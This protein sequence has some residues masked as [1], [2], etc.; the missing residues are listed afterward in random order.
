MKSFAETTTEIRKK[1]YAKA[2]HDETK[3]MILEMIGE[4]MYAYANELI[5]NQKPL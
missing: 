1:Y 3:L 4:I 5:S 2:E